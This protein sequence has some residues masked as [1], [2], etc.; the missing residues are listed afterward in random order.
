MQRSAVIIAELPL[1]HRA[2]AFHELDQSYAVA[3]RGRDQAAAKWAQSVVTGVRQLVTQID[4]S[5]GRYLK[6][7]PRLSRRNG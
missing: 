1:E 6:L 2:A 5:G 3:L 4:N 7:T